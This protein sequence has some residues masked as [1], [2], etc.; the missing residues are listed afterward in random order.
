MTDVKL[1]AQVKEILAREW[2]V[3][4]AD[5]PE[6]AALNRYDRWD[7]LGHISTMLA[8]SSEYAFELTPELVQS[9]TSLDAIVALVSSLTI[10]AR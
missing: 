7:S 10:G 4:P 3:N 2:G 1:R 9:L 8:L 5:I 6:D